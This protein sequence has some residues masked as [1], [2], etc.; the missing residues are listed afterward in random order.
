VLIHTTVC[1][2]RPIPKQQSHAISLMA[3]CRW[4]H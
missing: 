1:S 2:Q 3:C 4:Q